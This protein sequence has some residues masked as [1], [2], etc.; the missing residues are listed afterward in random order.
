MDDAAQAG[1][2]SAGHAFD[3]DTLDA[4]TRYKLLT[5][6]IVPRPI[7]WVT[8]RDGA[9]RA[10]AAPYSFFNAVSATPPVIVIGVAPRPTGG[11]FETKDTGANIAER[12]DFV[13]NL[14]DE[15]HAKAMSLTA[16]DA[17]AGVDEAALAGLTLVEAE[18]VDAPRIATAPI[19][20]ECRLRQIVDLG[21]HEG[22]DRGFIVGDV[23]RI[24]A[25]ADVLDP[26]TMRVDEAA[27]RPVG[28]LF[29]TL[30]ARQA[31]RFRLDRPSYA[32]WVAA[33]PKTR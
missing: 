13:V 31:D 19:A 6:T 33:Q 17:P 16:I 4:A 23:L 28:R 12:G 8:T 9:G 15:A 21:T 2:V 10:N 25:R 11:G 29:G 22:A 26:E 5:G 24:H 14:V 32:D 7:A 20:F 18:T 30:Y 1:R 27:Y 3:L